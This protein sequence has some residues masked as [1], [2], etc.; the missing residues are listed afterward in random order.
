VNTNDTPRPDLPQAHGLIPPDTH[1]QDQAQEERPAEEPEDQA[2]APEEPAPAGQ[3]Q[4]PEE[5]RADGSAALLSLDQAAAYAGRK[6]TTLRR[7]LRADK[8]PRH[9]RPGLYG[10][11]L[12]FAPADL[13]AWLSDMAR[14]VD[15]MPRTASTAK[16]D[17]DAAAPDD[18]PQEPAAD[19]EASTALV[20]PQTL[21]DPLRLYALVALAYAQRLHDVEEHA[22]A[23]E[24]R[25]ATIEEQ[26][27]AASDGWQL[28]AGA[29][30]GVHARLADLEKRQQQASQEPRNIQERRGT[31]PDRRSPDAVWIGEERRRADRRAQQDRERFEET[32]RGQYVPPSLVAVPRADEFAP[33]TA[34]Q[35]HADGEA[36][37]HADGEA[38]Q[39]AALAARIT[40]LE[41][42]LQ[43]GQQ[44]AATTGNVTAAPVDEPPLAIPAPEPTKGQRGR[45]RWE[46]AR[47]ALIRALS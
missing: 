28:Q 43:Q 10:P 22:R 39:H 24:E 38:Q 21:S 5:E 35:Q 9:Y 18:A 15:A 31:G 1:A 14:A 42:R 34:A 41:A 30:A 40:Q 6:P 17:G 20:D 25:L 29:L 26:A 7:A 12:V 45:S 4:E 33:P 3:P 19:G 36:Q 47:A 2:A 23:V 13:D 11:E 8:L 37:Q 32:V 44:Q 27:R 46:K 16:S